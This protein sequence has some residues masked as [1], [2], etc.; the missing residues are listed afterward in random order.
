MKECRFKVK[1]MSGSAEQDS[2]L[3]NEK[4]LGFNF[5]KNEIKRNR[6]EEADK[7]N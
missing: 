5:L 7:D 3:R 4:S 6:N 2:P 1:T